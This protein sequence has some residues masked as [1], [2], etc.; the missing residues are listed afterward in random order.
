M[1]LIL[2]LVILV[3]FSAL[4][5]GNFHWNDKLASAVDREEAHLLVGG[6]A[7]SEKE[8]ELEENK[9]TV[10]DFSNLPSESAEFI[11]EKFNKD[12]EIELVIIGSEYTIAGEQ[13]WSTMF[14]EKMEHTYERLFNITIIDIPGGATTE[15]VISNDLINKNLTVTPDFVILEP[16]LLESNG[17]IDIEQSLNHISTM[18]DDIKLLNTDVFIFLQPAQPLHKAIYYPTEVEKLK[19]VAKEQELFYID[20]WNNNWPDYHSDEFLEYIIPDT[21]LPNE[22][23]HLIWANYILRLFSIEEG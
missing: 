7:K 20:H 16:F 9:M 6:A 21:I 11:I 15:E 13:S 8:A 12:E 5:Y 2:T 17:I 1:R 18:I 3:C 14:K 23:G 10:D 22:K 19:N 4:V